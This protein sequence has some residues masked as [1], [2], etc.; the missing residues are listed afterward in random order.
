VA[1][2]SLGKAMLQ[3]A[4]GVSERRKCAALRFHRSPQRYRAR[5]DSPAHLRM[6]SCEI[7]AVRVRYGYSR[8]HALLQ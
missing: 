5:R 8:I 4:F 1:E 3:D 6:R 7:A 2:L